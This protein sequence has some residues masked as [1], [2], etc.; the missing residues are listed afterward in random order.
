MVSSLKGIS[1]KFI[2][3]NKFIILSSIFSILISV[4]LLIN[5]FTFIGSAEQSLRD[6]VKKTYGEMDLSV[7]FNS[8][9]SK[10]IDINM[11]NKIQSLGNIKE[12]SKVLIGRLQ[13]GNQQKFEVYSVGIDND[14]LSKSRYH[15][16]K[17]V[18]DNDVIV[19]KGLAQVLNVTEGEKVTI[20]DRNFKVIEIIDDMKLS[21]SVMDMIFINRN[22]F[23]DM[24]KDDREATYIMIR[25]IDKNKNYDLVDELIEIDKDLR[26][27]IAE[28]NEAV[29]QNI[30]VFKIYMTVLSV[31]VIIMCS[32]FIISNFQTFLYN[33]RN[34]FA[35]IRAIGGTSKQA[36]RI[37][38]TQSTFINA[39]G[40]ISAILFSYISS[41]FLID[42]FNN[43]FVIKVSQVYFS[44]G[45]A[46]TIA[47]VAFL[48]IELFMLIPAL[49]SSKILP[50]KI[51]QENEKNSYEGKHGKKLGIALIIISVFVLIF[52][53]ARAENSENSMLMG[54]LSSALLILGVY[55]L[56][57]FY[58]KHILNV[59]LPILE[60]LGGRVAF[61]AVKNLVPQVRKNSVIILSISTTI[62]IAVFGG[63]ILNTVY[64]NTEI[65]IKNEF[66]LNIAVT[67][68]TKLD[69][70]LGLD[71]KN[72]L[73]K[74]NGVRA[75]SVMSDFS[76]VYYK[77]EKGLEHLYFCYVNM[78]TLVKER[79]IPEIQG[80]FK[81]SIV[82]TEEYAQR[83]NLKV[84]D[85]INIKKELDDGKAIWEV[86]P[87]SDFDTMKVGAI[88]ESI[89][90]QPMQLVNAI[91]DWSNDKY[92]K[93][94]IIFYK[95]LIASNNLDDTLNDLNNLKKQYPQI[96]WATLQQALD[97]SR[98]QFYQNY[99]F[100]IIVIII[101]LLT[102]FVGLF[103][104][105][106]NNMMSK[107][108]EFAILR[109][110]DLNRTG[111]V[112]VV[113]TQ[114]LVYNLLGIILGYIMGIAVSL[115][116]LLMD[117]QSK[118]VLDNKLILVIS[119]LLFLT[120]ILI[121][122]P[123]SIKL[124]KKKIS[125]EINFSIK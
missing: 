61:V 47:L 36:L 71:F 54:V 57:Q 12:I 117:S 104:S 78:D 75:T 99:T 69:S 2:R 31:L 17:D 93:D 63:T 64:T 121:F 7:G 81:S 85:T 68:R 38:L 39:I 73:D 91:F 46:L 44:P 120:S 95:A 124:S 79:I 84:G 56:F 108:K 15:L 28:E 122:V 112:K 119:S 80:D 20:N 101:I 113:I 96:K 42:L 88:I 103:N 58:T 8:D 86:D 109:T 72:D 43:I 50:N 100:F 14:K 19:N 111:V 59:L 11:S 5:L 102:L 10:K 110:L 125:E 107:R 90:A 49:N 18:S 37:V 114:V 29:K 21:S 9:S 70:K 83:H 4:S 77:A 82:I 106:I 52:G 76:S 65:N 13:V 53:L 45:T 40:V 41:K 48:I 87:N 33:Y 60:I 35:L 25:S 24:V 94:N 16:V 27:D 116:I 74:L 62:I 51:L 26:I 23:K 55:R 3:S 118:I 123:F 30:S 22:T 32:L 115:I 92:L 105:L 66:A 89:P 67:D 6:E 98:Q 97:D 34:Q 1:F